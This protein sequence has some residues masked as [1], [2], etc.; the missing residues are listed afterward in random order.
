MESTCSVPSFL[1]K[2]WFPFTH[3]VPK[4]QQQFALRQGVFT[5]FGKTNVVLFR[6]IIVGIPFRTPYP[7][8]P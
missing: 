7:P 6:Q 5:L 4:M 8:L 1:L 2:G 3:I